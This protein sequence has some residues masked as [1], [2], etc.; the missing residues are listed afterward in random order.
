MSLPPKPC[1]TA[2]GQRSERTTRTRVLAG[3]LG[4]PDLKERIAKQM[5]RLARLVPADE[6]DDETTNPRLG[7]W[8]G[9]ID[10]LAGDLAL[11]RPLDPLAALR[12]LSALDDMIGELDGRFDGIDAILA[13]QKVMVAAYPSFQV[14]LVDGG[15]PGL[16]ERVITLVTENGLLD[17]EDPV[18]RQLLDALGREGRETV[19]LRLAGW[20]RMASW[21]CWDRPRRVAEILLAEPDLEDMLTLIARLDLGEVV[22]ASMVIERLLAEG[23]PSRELLAW[24]R[25]AL[26]EPVLDRTETDLLVE[27]C[28]TRCEADG[29]PDL[30]RQIRWEV[31]LVMHL[32]GADQVDRA[33]QAGP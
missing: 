18:P 15:A 10:R 26:H 16:A 19:A 12:G 4:E 30:A 8:P 32:A 31:F 33:P 28:A 25:R 11:L 2:P 20:D 17:D 7:S 13:S 6:N 22:S 27:R 29:Q 23:V 21:T 1:R 24:V 9:W 14:A 5:A 3:S